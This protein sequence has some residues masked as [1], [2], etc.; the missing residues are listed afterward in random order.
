[1]R[2]ELL[3]PKASKR[4]AISTPELS[5]MSPT[6]YLKLAMQLESSAET[7]ADPWARQQ[8]HAMADTYLMLARSLVVLQKSNEMLRHLDRVR[9]Q[10]STSSRRADG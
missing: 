10:P 1:M 8:R 9:R 7:T 5:M 6:E 4:P 2:T 3:K